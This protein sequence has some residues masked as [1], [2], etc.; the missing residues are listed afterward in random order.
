M[1][2]D[3]EMK[4][5]DTLWMVKKG[6]GDGESNGESNEEDKDEARIEASLEVKGDPGLP[7]TI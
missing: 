1:Q 3:L 7:V 2:Q 6:H 4:L 5:A